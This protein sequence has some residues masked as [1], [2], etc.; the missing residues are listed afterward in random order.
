M[1]EKEPTQRTPQGAE[2]PIP[3]RGQV[4]DDLDKALKPASSKLRRKRRP[5]Q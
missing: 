4:F 2:I 1:A 5:K 3:T